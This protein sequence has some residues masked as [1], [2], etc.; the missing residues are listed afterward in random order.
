[1]SR[2]S[3]EPKLDACTRT[4]PKDVALPARRFVEDARVSQAAIADN[5]ILGPLLAE[6]QK[7]QQE[8]DA[9]TARDKA[10]APSR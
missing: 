1:M 7:R 2:V 10:P 4:L 9:E 5:K 8:R 6:I 3:V